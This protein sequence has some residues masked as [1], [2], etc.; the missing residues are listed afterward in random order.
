MRC[1]TQGA[2]MSGSATSDEVKNILVNWGEGP[3]KI[4]AAT[5]KK[6]GVP[7]EAT[8]SCLVWGPRG[9]WNKI[10]CHR[11]PIAHNWPVPHI[12]VLEQQV[13]YQYPLNRYNDV[14]MFDG[15]I[16][17]QRTNGVISSRCDSEGGNYL[18]LNLAHEI[19][20][21]RRAWQDC[22][23]FYERVIK[24]AMNGIPHPYMTGFVFT[25]ATSPQGDPDH[26]AF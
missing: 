11:I 10:I 25:P 16:V 9:V 7:D 17:P 13:N 26:R 24:N 19:A 20:T 5:I 3:Q 21:N 1:Y 22:R 6:Y 15:S 18:A 12:D 14:V 23:T 4:A 8:D 2:S